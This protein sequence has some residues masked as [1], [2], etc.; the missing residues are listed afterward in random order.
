M[1]EPAGGRIECLEQ[2]I[3][4]RRLGSRERVQEGGLPDVRVSGQR[5]GRRARP[6]SLLPPRRA[7]SLESAEPLLEERY[8][9]ASE[10]PVGLELT[11]TRASS[12]DAA[13]E[14]LEVLPQAAH[15]RQ[16]VLEL[17]QL[18]LE[19][20]LRAACVLR[21]DVEDQ[22][23]AVDDA[24]LQRVFEGPLLRRAQLVVDE[25]RFGVGVGERLLQLRQL[26]LPDERARI[27]VH[28]IL[29]D[30][31]DRLDARRPRELRELA[32]LV[33]RIR[34]L[35]ED[36]EKEPALRLR[37]GCGIGLARSHREIMP[38]YAPAVT[39]LADRLAARTLELVD[40]PSQSGQEAA[41]RE[42]VLELVPSGWAADYAGDEAFLFVSPSP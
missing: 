30:L 3:V 6:Y 36:G 17:R 33:G 41:I 13:S 2:A 42:R 5:D 7:L 31:A 37:P 40:I 28:A 12:P 23:R 10:A 26:P 19:L 27:R 34:A 32:E 16:V 20:A 15:A 25:Q 22:L 38:R 18:D 8:P 24:R 21:E 29:D 4:D 39:A 11:L 9:R 1:L 35:R 14:A